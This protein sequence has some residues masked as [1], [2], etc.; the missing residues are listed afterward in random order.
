MRKFFRKGILF[1]FP[2]ALAAACMV[3]MLIAQCFQLDNSLLRP[4]SAATFNDGWQLSSRLSTTPMEHISRSLTVERRA[5]SL[6]NTLPE[7]NCDHLSLCFLSNNEKVRV[8][9]GSE[10]VY[11][12]GY[13]DKTLFGRYFGKVWCMVPLREDMSG[14]TISV[15]LTALSGEITS[16][17]YSF[18]LDDRET[19]LI[20][21]LMNVW[22]I[23]LNCIICVIAGIVLIVSGLLYLR[24]GSKT[25]L[26][27][28]YL[29]VFVLL[30]QVYVFSDATLTQFL[31]PNKAVSY[32]IVH[33]SLMLIPVPF[34]LYL[35]ELFPRWTR[36]YRFLSL[37]YC[38]YFALRLLLY[39]GGTIE[40]GQNVAFTLGLIL[41]GICYAALLCLMDTSQQ[42]NRI[43][44]AGLLLFFLFAFGT[45]LLFLSVPS[46]ENTLPF[47]TCALALGIDIL[48]VFFY[49]VLLK[50]ALNTANHALLY[51]HQ[52]YTDALTQVR[53]RAAFNLAITELVPESHPRLTL[54]MVDLNNLKQVND[55]LG[56]PAG[57][58]LICTLAQ[59]LVTAFGSVG[60]IYR[61]GGDE[62]VIV[63]ADA[64]L[65]EAQAARGRLDQLIRE[66]REHGGHAISVAIGMASRLDSEYAQAS[67]TEL[68]H[69]AD[70]VMYQIKAE[71]KTVPASTQLARHMRL[72][73]MDPTT[74][75]L[76]FAAFKSQVYEALTNIEV[77]LPCI[78]NF[79]L[80][81]FDGYNILFGWNAGNAL[82]QKMTAMAMN[83]CGET[84]FCSHDYADS[85]WVFVD[86]PDLDTLGERI[87]R[88]ARAFQQSLDECLLFPSF[89]VYCINERTLPVSDMCS[90]ATSAKKQ[91]KGHLDVLYNVYSTQEHQRRTHNMKMISYM[92]KALDSDEFIPYYQ[93]KFTCDGRLAGAEALVRWP[94]TPG[95]PS[96]PAEFTALFEKSGLILSLDWYMLEKSC[97]FLRKY[98]DAGLRCVP[99]SNNFS[100]LHIFE[101]DCLEHMLRLVDSYGVPHSLIEIELTE[102]AL[103]QDTQRI[104]AL[105]SALQAEGFSVSLDDFGSGVSSLGSLSNLSVNTIKIDRSLV[106]N[107]GAAD[108]DNLIL[109]FVVA[110]CRRLNIQTLAEGVETRKQLDQLRRCS[111]DLVQG[112]YFSPPLS[113]QAFEQL[114]TDRQD[115][116]KNE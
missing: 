108:T 17:N 111:C 89:G 36:Q 18:Y 12:Y 55:T 82:L 32:F 109:E 85:F 25:A 26:A 115:E 73:Q 71:Q 33:S 49:I 20:T 40:I 88:E 53:N 94:R 84:G 11:T 51:K 116:L 110:L 50:S 102:T 79:D 22:P 1:V 76:S 90:R 13:N 48:M 21:L 10:T 2:L 81:F 29:G 98:M 52:A 5:L 4:G 43:M 34:A 106:K 69:L 104:P 61:Y 74:G 96:S 114:L 60:D 80:N 105:I 101:P 8:T 107:Q 91:I 30:S 59:C 72:E 39:V 97:R 44:L 57:D 42:T 92:Q 41:L 86:A 77:R 58:Q 16:G 65:E 113:Q 54:F 3:I 23:L 87:T 15:E 27:R 24:A 19:I 63:L 78:I 47:Y 46:Q 56:H 31:I 67:A 62:F 99:I 38:A 70:T 95:S 14:K 28:I 9:V 7:L 45:V 64:S 6:K 75:I 103:V 68:L 100:R 83:L 37:F 93:P 112:N 35:A 66:H